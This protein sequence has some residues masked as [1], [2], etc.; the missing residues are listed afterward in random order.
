M[1][2]RNPV[3]HVPPFFPQIIHSGFAEPAI[4][5]VSPCHDATFHSMPLSRSKILLAT[6]AVLLLAALTADYW[7]RS[8]AGVVI[9]QAVIP[10][11]RL[12]VA[13]FT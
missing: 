3:F 7:V 13:L 2:K 4:D 5:G 6:G 10:L 9:D 12:I 11:T 8:L 1:E